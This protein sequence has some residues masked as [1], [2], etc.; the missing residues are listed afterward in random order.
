MKNKTTSTWDVGWDL[1]VIFDQLRRKTH[2]AVAFVLASSPRVSFGE[3]SRVFC[4]FGPAGKGLFYESAWIRPVKVRHVD[5]RQVCAGRRKVE[6]GHHV[7]VDQLCCRVF[8][9]LLHSLAKE[10]GVVNRSLVQKRIV[11]DNVRKAINLRRGNAY[12]CPMVKPPRPMILLLCLLSSWDNTWLS[13]VSSRGSSRVKAWSCSTK[14]TCRLSLTEYDKCC[15]VN[16]LHAGVVL[17]SQAHSVESGLR[18]QETHS[19]PHHT[20]ALRHGGSRHH[21]P[22]CACGQILPIQDDRRG[23]WTLILP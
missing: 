7:L 8:A 2:A 5:I 16:D 10:D 4:V 20:C 11:P 1:L 23:V 22:G 6:P 18:S 13:G 17:F 3:G 12:P 21:Y 14:S 15:R 9:S 19:P